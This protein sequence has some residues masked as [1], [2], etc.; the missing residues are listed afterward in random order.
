MIF[1]LTN[2]NVSLWEP[3]VKLVWVCKKCSW[4]LCNLPAPAIT[5]LW[6]CC[7]LLLWAFDTS[8]QNIPP[9]NLVRPL[10]VWWTSRRSALWWSA[11]V[12]LGSMSANGHFC[13]SAS[14]LSG[15]GRWCLT[16]LLCCLESQTPAQNAAWRGSCWCALTWAVDTV[17]SK[18]D[19]AWICMLEVQKPFSEL[20][21]LFVAL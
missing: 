21:A 10:L 5:Q 19:Q 14:M 16:S 9:L 4:F 2:N 20:Y 12:Y 11:A 6:M 1:Q 18:T 3:V 13:L 8:T 7:P 17:I 15:T